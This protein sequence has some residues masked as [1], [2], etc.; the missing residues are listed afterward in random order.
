MKG[1]D[2][3]ETI[4]AAFSPVQADLELLRQ[5]SA[6]SMVI[7]EALDP[8]LSQRN[9]RASGYVV[10]TVSPHLLAQECERASAR[11]AER[12][13]RAEAERR[14]LPRRKIVA[15]WNARQAGDIRSGS[16]RQSGRM[17]PASPSSH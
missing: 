5:T 17:P 16:T 11:A 3:Y 8:S 4:M 10:A 15:I 7:E 12:A 9:N 13:K 6:N 1:F 14:R 2:I